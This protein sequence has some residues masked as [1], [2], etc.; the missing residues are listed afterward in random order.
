MVVGYINTKKTTF[1]IST[2]FSNMK[3]KISYQLA[4]SLNL[5]VNL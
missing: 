1:D 5:L 2:K 4:T 3:I